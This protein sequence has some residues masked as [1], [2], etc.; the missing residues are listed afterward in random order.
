MYS[1]KLTDLAGRLSVGVAVGADLVTDGSIGDLD[2][3]SDVSIIVHQVEET[4]LNKDLRKECVLGSW[5]YIHRPK[6][7]E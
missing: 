2:V 4:I 7:E 3:L 6:R 5:Y 1:V